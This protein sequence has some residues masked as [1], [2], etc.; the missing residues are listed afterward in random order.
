MDKKDIFYLVSILVVIFS[1]IMAIY[2]F[3][4]TMFKGSEFEDK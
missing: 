1:S 3:I 4:K 2:G